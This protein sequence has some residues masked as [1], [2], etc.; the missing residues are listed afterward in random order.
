[1]FY[2]VPVPHFSLYPTQFPGHCLQLLLFLLDA[3]SYAVAFLLHK[4]YNIMKDNNERS[5]GLSVSKTICMQRWIF[6]MH[7]YK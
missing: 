1:M 6:L 4:A 2:I 3:V 5:I 7:S